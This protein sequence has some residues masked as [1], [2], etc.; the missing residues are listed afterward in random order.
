M[1]LISSIQNKKSEFTET[2][3]IITS[4]LFQESGVYNI[5]GIV[6]ALLLT[7]AMLQTSTPP[8]KI[9]IWL[10]IILLAYFG[11][12]LLTLTFNKADVID[13]RWLTRFRISVISTGLIWSM[14]SFLLFQSHDIHSQFILSFTLAGICAGAALSYSIDL[15]LLFG[16]LTPIITS[17]LIRL[18]IEG[19]PTSST[20]ASM[21]ILYLI[22]LLASGRKAYKLFHN[23]IHLAEIASLGEMKEKH[24]N[25]ILK[26]LASKSPLDEILT[27]IVKNLEVLKPNMLCSILLL[28]VNNEHIQFWVAP[29]LPDIYNQTIERKKIGVGT[30][31]AAAFA[32]KRIIVEDIQTNPYWESLRGIADKLNLVSSWSEPITNSDGKILGALDIYHQKNV[33][34]NHADIETIKENAYMVG[35][36]IELT[37]T[38]QELQLAAML[39]QNSKESMMITDAKNL[40][41]AVNPAFTEATGYSPSHVVGKDPKI[42]NSGEQDDM[43]FKDMW[44]ELNSN[45]R[46]EGEIYNRRKSGE[47]FAEWIRISTI[48]D[49]NGAVLNRVSV[50]TDVTVKKK[51]EETIWRQAN[52]DVLTGL[53]NRHMFL[54]RFQ[55]EINKSQRAKLPLA[56][57]L[58]DI[59]NFKEV[60]DALGHHEGDVLLKEA[61]RRLL[62]CVQELDTAAH[63][64]SVARLGGDEFTII[65]SK[66]KDNG[67]VERIANKILET[68]AEPFKLNK[69]LAYVSASI[70]ITI[71]PE[72]STNIDTLI[73]NADQA[74]YVAKREGRNQFS[75][76]TQSMQE[77]T[78][79]RIRLANDLRSAVDNQQF[80]LLYQ[81]IVDLSTGQINKAEA[82]IRWQ[83][84]AIGL[85]SPVEFIPIAEGTGIINDIGSWLFQEVV[86]QVIAW[87]KSLN[88]NFQVSINVSPVQFES[89]KPTENNPLT[90]WVSYLQQLG[91]PGQSITVE[92]T[93]GLLLDSHS[94]VHT[95]LSSFRNSGI[96]ISLDDFGT[97]YSS[98]SYLKKFDIDYIK[99]DRS[100]VQNLDLKSSD[101]ALCE[102][103]IVMAHKLGLKVIAE[104]IETQQHLDLLKTAGCDFGQGYFFSKPIT[105]K[106][107]KKLISK[108]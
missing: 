69:D 34:P 22:Y 89:A 108:T 23:S 87:R 86:K 100:F 68:I 66:L 42:L 101:L 58:I 19:T 47:I 36:S 93:E 91:L 41:I 85:V 49:D 18:F 17:L 73:K 97:G 57:M 33:T 1:N 80:H 76:F 25:Q 40:I 13:I 103:I 37:N 44:D 12:V 84:P 102:A 2:Q 32:G 5:V 99:I 56:L 9:Y 90:N 50:A 52:F 48:Y 74:M 95:Q 63:I 70:G 35:F 67:C 51:S 27:A 3:R 26:L 14:T 81:P 11:R 79:K 82:L 55:V 62:N 53:P 59:D 28:D 39:Y 75:Y 16:F 45:G 4:Q 64:E 29:S 65:L 94:K 98:L 72:D 104:G 43:F 7:F 31:G 24:S 88:P 107:L 61:A 46:W 106:N 78:L 60:N 54:D 8:A 10:G 83:H 21:L 92:I 77:A 105:A 20:L 71:Y 30:F 38:N 96:Q 6:L 15:I